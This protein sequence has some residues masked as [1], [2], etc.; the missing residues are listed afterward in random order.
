MPS[1]QEQ[2]HIARKVAKAL[3][4]V[5]TIA[6]QS[7]K[8]TEPQSVIVRA[9]NLL[10]EGPYGSYV[11][12]GDPHGWSSGGTPYATIYMENKGGP[13]DCEKPMDYYDDGFSVSIAASDLLGGYFIEF[14]NA[15]IAHVWKA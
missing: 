6:G 10:K 13:D 7:I 1:K 3:A 8:T 15:A 2:T 5:N 9:E 11:A 12:P 4:T 14:Y